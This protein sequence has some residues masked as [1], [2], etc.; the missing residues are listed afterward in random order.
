VSFFVPV[1]FGQSKVD[2]VDFIFVLAKAEAEV[3]RLDIAMDDPFAVELLHGFDHL[4]C[5]QEHA[6]ERQTALL[7]PVLLEDALERGSQ[8][9]HDDD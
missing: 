5:K 7:F 9:V 6:S 3:G 2:Y 8:H 1:F 4:D